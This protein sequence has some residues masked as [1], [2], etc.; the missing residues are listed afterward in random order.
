MVDNEDKGAEVL[1]KTRYQLIWLLYSIK[2]AFKNKQ[3]FLKHPKGSTVFDYFCISC[4][5]RW[6]KLLKVNCEQKIV[7]LETL[8]NFRLTSK[9]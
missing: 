1:R 7:Q 8:A 9:L 6:E 3:K 4:C 2:N 5:M